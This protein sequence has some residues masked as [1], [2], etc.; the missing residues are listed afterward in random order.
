MRRRSRYLLFTFAALII[1]ALTWVFPPAGVRSFALQQSRAASP[2]SP[3]VV[4]LFTSEGCSSCPPADRLLAEFARQEVDGVTVIPLG[5]HVDY[6]NEEG[7]HDRFSSHSY[8]E[9]QEQY[10]RDLRT[11]SVYTPQAVI[12]GRF[13]AVGN[14][15][16]EIVEFIRRAASEPK[17][18]TIELRP[19]SPTALSI[20][21][22]SQPELKAEVLLAITEDD[23]STDVKGGEN[24]GHTLR[25]G[26][27]VRWLGQI[28]TLKAG[29]FSSQP[30][31][32]LKP[33]WRIEK[34][35]A[36]VF[37]Q[38]SDGK[39]LGAATVTLAENPKPSNSSA[40]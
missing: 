1:G 11:D 32:Q 34:L 9:R 24:G 26:A 3:V 29:V 12:D 15:K 36:V 6:W 4:E 25:H 19:I 8:T 22:K 17:P 23:L 2:L 31:L 20:N 5:L 7:W 10:S 33:D 13:Q 30:R 14:Q 28:G 39:I 38:A 18:V 21:C 35:H 27:V 16:G 40:D 37:A